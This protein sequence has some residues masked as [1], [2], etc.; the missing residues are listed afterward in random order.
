MA[1]AP[2][3]AYT[4]LP[5]KAFSGE[6]NLSSGTVKVMLCTDAYTPNQDTHSYKSS[7]TGEVANGN[8]YTTGGFTLA[9]KSLT[10][11]TANNRMVFDA[12][13]PEWTSATITARW[14]VFYVD[15][16]NPATSPLIAYQDFGGN[17]SCS[18]SSFKLTIPTEGIFRVN[19]PAPA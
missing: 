14:A 1:D 6:V 5:I 9:N 19:I 16:G 3:Y 2:I 12:D 17:I 7:V 18:G 10:T 8:G 4:N 15:T 11:D 13:D